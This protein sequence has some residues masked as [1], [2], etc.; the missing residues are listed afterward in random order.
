M[1]LIFRLLWVFLSQTLGRRS[2]DVFTV[3]RVHSRALPNDLDLNLHVNNGRLMTFIDFG[4]IDWLWQIGALQQAYRQRFIPVIGDISVRYLKPLKVFERFTIESRVLGWDAKWG[5]F[6]HRLLKDNGDLVLLLVNRG[7]FWK[8]GTGA[9][10]IAEVIASCGFVGI[11]S[12]A[13]PAWVQTW[14]RSLDEAR[15][16][17]KAELAATSEPVIQQQAGDQ[18]IE[19]QVGAAL[20]EDAAVG[21]LQVDAGVG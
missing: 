11:V 6:E 9:M 18:R 13:L 14:S 4:R 5:Y 21:R 16:A 10:P 17:Q 1:S 15:A 8:R 20:R 7:L 3:Q 2:R 19:H 12:P